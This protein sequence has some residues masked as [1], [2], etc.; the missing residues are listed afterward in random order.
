MVDDDPGQLRI[1]EIILRNAGM[2]SLLAN[3]AA[4]AL[5]RLRDSLR[6]GLRDKGSE[7]GLVITDHN[8]PGCSGA[9][10]VRQIRQVAPT[11]PV[12]VLTGM[13]GVEPEYEGLDVIFCFKPLP[14]DEF[15]RVVREL[16]SR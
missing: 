1:R 10:L 4:A 9:E 5:A 15:I 7:I 6:D 13:P 8:L 2:A 16:L 12:V 11:M 14:P 3:D